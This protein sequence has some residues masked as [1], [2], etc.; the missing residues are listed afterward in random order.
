MRYTDTNALYKLLKR[1]GF[2]YKKNRLV[3][4]KADPKLQT[5]FVRWFADLCQRLGPESRI[6][7]GDAVHF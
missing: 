7:F 2:S 4:S 5:L 3:L 6:H 1:L